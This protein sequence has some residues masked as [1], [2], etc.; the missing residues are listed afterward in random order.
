MEI[1][2][3]LHA[4]AY[5]RGFTDPKEYTSY[6]FSRVDCMNSDG[7]PLTDAGFSYSTDMFAWLV[8]QHIRGY[9]LLPPVDG[10]GDLISI[11]G[12]IST[13]FQGLRAEIVFSHVKKMLIV[14]EDIQRFDS[15][16]EAWR[17][18]LVDASKA[19]D[20]DRE[21]EVIIVSPTKPFHWDE[22]QSLRSRTRPNFGLEPVLADAAA[23]KQF[24]QIAEITNR[25]DTLDALR[26]VVYLSVVQ[27]KWSDVHREVEALG[28]EGAAGI[29]ALAERCM[30]IGTC[31][32]R[33]PEY[34]MPL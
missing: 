34:A 13:G 27:A 4:E 25:I 33:R 16:D 9:F 3:R 14:A 19:F 5:A 29:R 11:C 31:L 15:S 24:A 12:T 17:N 30:T 8:C 6:I 1:V 28:Q 18:V 10:I 32:D 7:T 21:R 2:H 20:E 26:F 23:R 22:I